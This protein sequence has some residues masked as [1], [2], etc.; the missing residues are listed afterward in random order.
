MKDFREMKRASC[1]FVVGTLIVMI[2][3]GL[4]LRDLYLWSAQ[5]EL[6]ITALDNKIEKASS[7]I[8]GPAELQRRL[9][10]A[11][12]ERPIKVDGLV[13][14]QMIAKWERVYCNQSAEKTFSKPENQ[15]T[16]RAINQNLTQ[17]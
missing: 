8:P 16:N 17:K 2:L 9:N 10:R 6:K 13:G 1:V 12:P 5:L 14:P 7:L 3:F 11:E 4:K 15:L